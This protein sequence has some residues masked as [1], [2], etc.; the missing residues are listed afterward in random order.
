MVYFDI[1]A[2]SGTF[3]LS[4]KTG[5]NYFAVLQGLV[6]DEYK[7]AI[8]KMISCFG[9]GSGIVG[10]RSIVEY[11]AFLAKKAFDV[12]LESLTNEIINRPKRGGNR[13]AKA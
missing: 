8:G 5:V 11:E 7:D 9:T 6:Q 13:N 10:G 12:I 1:R 2:N 4:R 3:D